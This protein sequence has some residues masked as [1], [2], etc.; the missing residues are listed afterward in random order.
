MF[1]KLRWL[2]HYCAGAVLALLLIGLGRARAARR[3]ALNREVISA[4]AF[5]KPNRRLF[6]R[7]IAWL[8]ENG[9]TFIAADDV[10]EFLHRAKPIPQGAVWLSF[11]DGWKEFAEVLPLVRRH[12]IPITLFVPSGVLEGNGRFPWHASKFF[13]QSDSSEIRPC[14]RFSG[15]HNGGRTNEDRR[16]S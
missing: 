2:V 3:K 15:C 6:L 5:H 14:A 16:L 4:I 11:D 12:H 1:V 8:I 13:F 9:Y 7:C 10:V